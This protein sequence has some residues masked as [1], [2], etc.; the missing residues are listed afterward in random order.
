MNRIAL[1]LI[2]IPAATLMAFTGNADADQQ[3]YASFC[4]ATQTDDC[5]GISRS[6]QVFDF[7]DRKVIGKAVILKTPNG[8]VGR[9]GKG[10]FCGKSD[11]RI[12]K[13]YLVCTSNGWQIERQ[14]MNLAD[15]WNPTDPWAGN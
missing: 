6:G 1:S 4:S 13:S 12:S 9:F 5:I 7:Y 15:P 8:V 11:S 14:S 2:A 3:K 10:Y